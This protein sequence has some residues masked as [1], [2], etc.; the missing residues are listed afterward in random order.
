LLVPIDNAEKIGLRY[1]TDDEK[2]T[3]VLELF[4]QNP[5]EKLEKWSKRYRSN[6]DK[7]K[8]GD[9]LQLAEV[10]RNLLLRGNSALSRDGNSREIHRGLCARH[11]AYARA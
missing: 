1:L 6:M 3:E 11:R 10:V 7:L 2:M 5:D 9:I 4:S 8:S